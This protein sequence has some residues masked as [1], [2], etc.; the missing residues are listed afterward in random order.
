[1]KPVVLFILLGVLVLL[2]VGG[3][4]L[5]ATRDDGGGAD[6][7][8]DWITSVGD[9]LLPPQRLKLSDVSLASPQQCQ[10]QLQQGTFVLQPGSP[11]TL[12]IKSVPRS[13]R[14]LSLELSAGGPA[15]AFFDPRGEGSITQKYP[16]PDRRGRD[17]VTIRILDEGGRLELACQAGL[18]STCTLRV[19]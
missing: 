11:C 7:P 15:V 1:M 5:G 18:G 6:F 13:A 19:R 9:R 14:H 10:Q 8:P 12:L 4:V 17:R 16:L 2:A 3:V